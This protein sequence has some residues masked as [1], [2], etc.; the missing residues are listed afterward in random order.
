LLRGG[1]PA[2]RQDT[3]DELLLLTTA[4]IEAQRVAHLLEFVSTE[5]AEDLSELDSPA[6]S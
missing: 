6:V 1:S 3:V 4:V 2:A 5:L